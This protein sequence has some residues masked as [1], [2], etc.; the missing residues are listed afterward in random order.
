MF[1]IIFFTH[2]FSLSIY[3]F[4]INAGSK[5]IIRGHRNRFIYY[6]IWS[7]MSCFMKR[8]KAL[9]NFEV[10]WSIDGFSYRSGGRWSIMTTS[11]R[12]I[13]RFSTSSRLQ[14]QRY[15]CHGYWIGKTWLTNVTLHR[16]SRNTIIGQTTCLQPTVFPEVKRRTTEPK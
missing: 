6:I 15:S 9:I 13:W 4:D 10:M 8:L 12:R 1:I 5:G 14:S 11:S 16:S 2:L 7:Y 3:K